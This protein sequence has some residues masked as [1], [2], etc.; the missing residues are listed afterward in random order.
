MA[1]SV[2]SKIISSNGIGIID[3]KYS[4]D[5]TGNVGYDFDNIYR[6]IHEEYNAQA[7]IP[8]NSRSALL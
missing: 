2:G 8:L 1:D 4:Y 7:I 5:A 6:T 3:P